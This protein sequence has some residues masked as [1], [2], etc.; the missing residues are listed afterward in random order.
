MKKRKRTITEQARNYR[1][2]RNGASAFAVLAVVIVWGI[3]IVV[4]NIPQIVVGILRIALY[5]KGLGL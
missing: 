5:F 4:E 1:A 3:A 2:L